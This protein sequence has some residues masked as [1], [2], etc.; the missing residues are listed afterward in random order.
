[1]LEILL[2]SFQ[3]IF[4]SNYTPRNVVGNFLLISTLS[5]SNGGKIFGILFLFLA[6]WNKEYFVFE[7]LKEILLALNQV[8]TSL[9]TSFIVLER[10]YIL[11]SVINKFVLSA[12]PVSVSLFELLKR[13]FIY[14]RCKSSSRMEPCSTPQVIL[15]YMA[16]L[17][18]TSDTKCC[19][20]SK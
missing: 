11:N 15:Q 5:I 14:M 16:F 19:Q 13:S 9:N 4:S 8:S 18:F 6:E 3:E 2:W 7:I 10:Y 1:M 20:F 12:D 17:V